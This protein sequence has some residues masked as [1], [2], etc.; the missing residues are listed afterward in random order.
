[1]KGER[2]DYRWRIYKGKQH[3][4]IV[5]KEKQHVKNEKAKIERLIFWGMY[6]HNDMKY[7]L[8]LIDLWKLKLINWWGS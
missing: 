4:W 2:G 7:E 3:G 6:F 1:M 8:Y 5:K